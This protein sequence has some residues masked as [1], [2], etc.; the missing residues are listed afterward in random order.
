MHRILLGIF[1]SNTLTID[2]F[3]ALE[4][5]AAALDVSSHFQ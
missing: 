4:V 2:G 5:Q 3:V 1:T